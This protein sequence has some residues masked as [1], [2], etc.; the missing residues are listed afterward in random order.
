[1]SIPTIHDLTGLDEAE[2]A[3]AIAEN[4]RAYM[5]L[6]GAVAEKHLEKYLYWLQSQGMIKSFSRATSDFEKDF[7]V[8]LHDG[9]S[10]CIECK[11]AEVAKI[12]TKPAIVSYL[13]FLVDE[14]YIT[15]EYL[16]TKVRE[17][18]EGRLGLCED[19]FALLATLDSKT[20]KQT[21]RLMPQ[22]LRESG[23]S[24]YRY[25]ESLLTHALTGSLPPEEFLRQF[26]DPRNTK[27]TV[28]F[29]RT[30]NASEEDEENKDIKS[31]L[32]LV[33]EIDVLAICL[34]SRTMNWDFI[35]APCSSFDIHPEY[36]G[37]YNNRLVVNPQDWSNNLM[38]AIKLC[39]QNQQDNHVI[40]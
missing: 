24:R 7:R 5:A 8:F 6:K 36:T 31:R 13:S 20:L 35:F 11:N 22:S 38:D 15:L 25:S 27:V 32:Y 39:Q 17:A 34:F 4:P 30:R 28:D 19:I 2:L 14:N 18:L 21:L 23:I 9:S 29:Q 40:G 33:D 1:M 10:F 26:D 3:A 16:E 37:C 12:T